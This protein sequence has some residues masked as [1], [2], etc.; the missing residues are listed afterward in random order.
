M[1]P[2]LELA[3]DECHYPD[4]HRIG[5]WHRL[6]PADCTDGKIQNNPVPA[7]RMWILGYCACHHVKSL[8]HYS[9][10]DIRAMQLSNFPKGQLQPRTVSDKPIF[11]CVL[12][13]LIDI[14]K[15]NVEIF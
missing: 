3:R 5:T 1:T 11:S 2:F 8:L 7:S 4:H 9:P 6:L 13:D 14:F 12:G 10:P 15:L